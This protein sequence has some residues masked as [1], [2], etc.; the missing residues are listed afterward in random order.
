MTLHLD[1]PWIAHLIALAVYADLI[2]FFVWHR[3]WRETLDRRLLLYVGLGAFSSLMLIASYGRGV[4]GEVSELF[5]HLFVYTQAA[6]PIF[7]Y[8][9]ARAFIRSERR[10]YGFI[11]GAF[12]LAVLIAIDVSQFSFDLGSG[13]ISTETLVLLARAILWLVFS[14]FVALFTQ[15]EYLRMRSPMH[16]N[17]L[18]YLM[19]ASPFIF[20][21]GA[22]SLLFGQPVF[23]LAVALQMAGMLVLAYATFQHALVDLRTLLRRVVY[24]G[25]TT[26]FALLL[27]SLAVGVALFAFHD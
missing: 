14:G 15:R 22:L 25:V 17:R 3:R 7:F 27:Y 18:S 12:L 21:D 11:G 2:A 13:P 8:T 20:A 16:R 24:L 9:V 1:Y 26:T 4:F 5:F 23:P 19:L 6:L 10:P